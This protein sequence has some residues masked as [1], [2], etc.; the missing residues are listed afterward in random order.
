MAHKKELEPN[1]YTQV[2]YYRCIE[3]EMDF[4][5]DVYELRFSNFNDVFDKYVEFPVYEQQRNY[6]NY[7][8]FG[9]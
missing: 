3:S 4:N 2:Y 8:E 1:H 9:P 6:E 5:I 7:I